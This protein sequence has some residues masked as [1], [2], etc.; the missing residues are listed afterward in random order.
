MKFF[1]HTA[2]P[3]RAAP[4]KFF[5]KTLILAF[6]KTLI[7]VFEANSALSCENETKIVKIMH[8]SLSFQLLE[9]SD[10]LKPPE[11]IFLPLQQLQMTIHVSTKKPC[12]RQSVFMSFMT[13]NKYRSFKFY[14]LDLSPELYKILNRKYYNILLITVTD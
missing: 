7:L 2:G 1:L 10:P 3:F 11:H 14:L 4:F 5:L 6:Q 13:K 12:H 9:K 8:S